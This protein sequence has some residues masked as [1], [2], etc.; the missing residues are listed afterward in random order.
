MTTIWERYFLRETTKT[1][2]LFIGGF[3]GLYV[4]IDYSVHSSSVHHHAHFHWNQLTLYYLCEFVRRLDVMLPFALLIATV[5]TLFNLTLHHEL[6]ALMASGIKLKRLLRPFVQLGLFCV[7]LIY[8]NHELLLPKATKMLKRIESS[9]AK[10]RSK[11]KNHRPSVQ[12]LT[13][14]D[15]STILF[16]RYDPSLNRFFDAYWVRSA[17]DI[18]RIKYLYPEPEKPVGYFVDHLLRDVDGNLVIAQTSAEQSFPNIRLNKKRLINTISSPD[19]QS[20]SSLWEQIP[21]HQNLLS[22][23]EAQVLSSFYFKLAMPWL[24]LLAI[25]AP[26]PFC[27]RFSRQLPVFFVYAFSIFGLVSFH[28]VMNAANVL[29]SRQVV[30]PFWAIW[31]PFAAF[32]GYFI[33]RYA[34]LR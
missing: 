22:E 8:F 34:K 9:Y 4:L 16:Q 32:F 10:M 33:W 14:E 26:A 7:L 1:L 20:F 15:G 31:T 30:A 12:Y 29:G 5:K 23:K 6:V 2:L 13:L 21:L 11:K 27:V 24:C 18:Y 19:E 25:I 17:D 3:Y 28:L